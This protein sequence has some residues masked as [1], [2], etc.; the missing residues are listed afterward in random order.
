MENR[1]TSDYFL[2]GG[3]GRKWAGLILDE[4]IRERYISE[5]FQFG[6]ERDRENLRDEARTRISGT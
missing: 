3:G 4:I 5:G 1:G 2:V 6:F